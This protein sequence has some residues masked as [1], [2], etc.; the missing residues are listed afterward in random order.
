LIKEK[1]NK[2]GKF[3]GE[4]ETRAAKQITLQKLQIKNKE[5]RGEIGGTEKGGAEL[6]K[7]KSSRG[8]RRGG[9]T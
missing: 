3:G 9:R 2:P 8:S 7:K 4:K 5:K 6:A 1:K